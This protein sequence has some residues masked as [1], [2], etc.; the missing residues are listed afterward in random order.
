MQYWIEIQNV[1]NS[2][3]TELAEQHQTGK[4]A[5]TPVTN[6]HFMARWITRALKSQRF[7]AC[8]KNDLISWQK[9][10]RS[11][12]TNSGLVTTFE[13]IA[14]LYARFVPVDGQPQVVTDKQ[15]E[16]YKR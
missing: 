16:A 12:G 3:L 8:V 7:H 5:N 13:K 4:L 10:S 14:Q 15:I 11:Q 9:L 1:V 2:A 6:T